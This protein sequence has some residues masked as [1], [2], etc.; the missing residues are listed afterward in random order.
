MVWGY[1]PAPMRA[2]FS[3]QRPFDPARLPFFYGWVIVA[4]STLGVI[5]SIPGQTMGVSVFTDW[6]ITETGLTRL[7]LANAYLAGTLTSGLLLPFGGTLLDR[8]GAR[9]LVVLCSFGLGLTLV[10]MSQVGR[11]IHALGGAEIVAFAALVLCFVLLRFSG[12]G[13]LT[14]VSRTMLGKWFERR[15]GLVAGLSGLFVAFGFASAPLALSW[16]ID[17]AGFR[18]AWLALALVVGVG[19]SLVGW[20]FYRDNPEECD[21]CMDG[22][23]RGAEAARRASGESPEPEPDLTR[24]QA[25]RTLPFWT[26]TLALAFQALLITA[27]TFHIVD[28]GALAG[29]DRAHVV[30]LFLPIAVIST[31]VGF[32]AGWAADRV[33]MRALVLVMMLGQGLGVAC[34]AWLREPAFF[35]LTALGLGISGGLFGPLS[36]VALPRFFGR[37]HLGSIAGIQMMAIVIGSALGPSLLA[38]SK[39][40]TGQYADG[41]Y[42]GCIL[43]LSGLVLALVTKDPRPAPL[44]LAGRPRHQR[45]G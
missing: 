13:M 20:L 21:L 17:R 22:D 41:L 12:Q 44:T 30:A 40:F 36:T 27:V 2:L 11:L 6:L 10:L 34:A 42:L 28:I 18:G 3:P 23:A 24:A 9:A 8:W 26:V 5:M 35:W 33:P 39:S 1:Q 31:A 37:L 7:G 38:L 45:P 16:G 43:P 19:M 29:L 15:R 32:L 14:M 25:V 4:V